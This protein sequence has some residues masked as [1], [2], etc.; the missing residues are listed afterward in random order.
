MNNQEIHKKNELLAKLLGWEE[1]EG[2]DKGIWMENFGVA[3]VVAYSIHYSKNFPHEDLPFHRDYNYLMKI[4][5]K[6]ETITNG[7]DGRLGNGKI[8]LRVKLIKRSNG[9]YEAW[10][11]SNQ[12]PI[13]EHIDDERIMALWH[14]CVGFAEE[15]FELIK[16]S[17]K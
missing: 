13:H 11:V 8:L 6:I 17:Q 12:A 14:T 3:K 16:T 2:Y 9:R 5:D 15:Y 7:H 1:E 4:V 10:I